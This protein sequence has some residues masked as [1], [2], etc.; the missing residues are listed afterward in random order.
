MFLEGRGNPMSKTG[1]MRPEGETYEYAGVLAFLESLKNDP[2]K[3]E[4]F[5]AQANGRAEDIF[6]SGQIGQEIKKGDKVLYVGSGT[7]H[8]PEYIRQHTGADVVM[9]D[10][11]D[12]RT[13]DNKGEQSPFVQGNARRLP[14]A[15]G[16]FDVVCAF[17]MLHH[18]ANQTEILDELKRVRKP[19]GKILA[20]ENILPETFEPSRKIMEKFYG[21][22]DDAFNKQP[23]GVNPHNFRS[24]TEWDILLYDSGLRI[25]E[26]R[27]WT[28]G[29]PDFMGADRSGRKEDRTFFR[30]FKDGLMVIKD[31][32]KDATKKQE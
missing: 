22:M 2:K 31:L 18:T 13:E 30:P 26:E 1:S 4:R 5:I 28:W 3:R 20:L 24:L 12:L 25:S 19:E 7:G 8:V 14:F 6:E 16:S 32:P 9:L 23:K 15:D 10:L 17:D 27:T 29:I 21:L 11:V